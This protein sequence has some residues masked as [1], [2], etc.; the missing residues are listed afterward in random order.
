MAAEQL[1]ACICMLRYGLST[2]E[3]GL[4]GAMVQ[5]IS[6][7]YKVPDSNA[8]VVYYFSFSSVFIQPLYTCLINNTSK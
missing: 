5:I 3:E 1:H 4:A 8:N 6:S 2:T 7:Y